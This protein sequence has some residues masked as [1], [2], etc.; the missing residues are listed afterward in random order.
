MDM[1]IQSRVN[2]PDRVRTF[3]RKW[4]VLSLIFAVLAV[5]AATAGC[6][7]TVMD[8]DQM[9]KDQMDKDQMDNK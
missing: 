1:E 8:K 9:D 6:A 7:G 3:Y 5:P 4:S 2:M